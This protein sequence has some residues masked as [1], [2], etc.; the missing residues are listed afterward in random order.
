VPTGRRAA[1]RRREDGPP[2]SGGYPAQE[3]FESG[4]VTGRDVT[5]GIDAEP[6]EGLPREHVIGDV[7]FEQTVAVE[8]S[9]HA[10][11]HSLLKLVPVGGREV[12]GLVEMEVRVQGR[13]EGLFLGS[14][15]HGGLR[16]RG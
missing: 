11:S 10:V 2:T 7:A 6:A 4:T 12:S 1:A 13:A 5:R 16:I 3:S 9:E 14:R 15:V 8:V